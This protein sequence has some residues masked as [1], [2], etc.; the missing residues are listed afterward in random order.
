MLLMFTLVFLRYFKANCE[1]SEYT[2]IRKNKKRKSDVDI[3]YNSWR[4]MIP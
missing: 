1:E 4:V 3:H 2:L